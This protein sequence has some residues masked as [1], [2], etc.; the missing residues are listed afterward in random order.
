MKFD[1]FFEILKAVYDKKVVKEYQFNPYRKWRSDYAFP[2]YKILIEIE[3]GVWTKGRH[4]RGK[5]YIND[6]EKYNNAQKLGFRVLRYT[7]D[8]INECL[9]DL[10]EIM[11]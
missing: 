8:Q 7:P 9:S 6:M 5:G 11:S 1:P 10:N 2:K 4:V 3:G